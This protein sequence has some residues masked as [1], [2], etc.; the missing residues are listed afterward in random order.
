MN[1]LSTDP[2]GPKAVAI[3]TDAG[4]WL[5]CRLADGRKAYGIRSSEGD[6]YY[7]TT[8]T[9]CTC[10]ARMHRPAEDCK[11]ML[12]VQLHVE[13]MAEFTKPEVVEKPSRTAG[14]DRIL[15]KRRPVYEHTTAS[16]YDDIFARFDDDGPRS[17]RKEDYL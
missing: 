14:L 13:L 17:V 2:R 4:Q 9:W 16:K 8:R 12:A 6:R 15:S 3:A 11:H 7:L 1:M 10:P 5:K